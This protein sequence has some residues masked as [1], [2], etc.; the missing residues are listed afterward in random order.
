VGGRYDCGIHEIQSYRGERCRWNLLSLLANRSQGLR[1][2][3]FFPFRIIVAPNRL[4]VHKNERSDCLECSPAASDVGHQP[5]SHGIRT[6]HCREIMCWD[7]VHEPP[8]GSNRIGFRPPSF[9][10]QIKHDALRMPD[11]RGEKIFDA[12]PPHC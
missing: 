8:D 10:I 4:N 7:S 1:S 5:T 11:I 3:M 12:R 9:S 2:M 6:V